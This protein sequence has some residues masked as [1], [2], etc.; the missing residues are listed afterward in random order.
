MQHINVDL[1]QGLAPTSWFGGNTGSSATSCPTLMEGD[2]AKNTHCCAWRGRNHVPCQGVDGSGPLCARNLNMG[3]G[4]RGSG[5]TAPR[6]GGKGTAPT[7][8]CPLLKMQRKEQMRPESHSL[9][10]FPILF[11][12]KHRRVETIIF[13]NPLTTYPL[14]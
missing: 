14:C 13:Y 7:Q 11:E 6:S 1:Q 9:A 4:T 3:A 5:N 2:E 12:E 8:T 10:F